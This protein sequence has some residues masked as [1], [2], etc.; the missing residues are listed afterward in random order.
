ML[1]IVN[2]FLAVERER[3]KLILPKGGVKEL[4]QQLTQQQQQV[5]LAKPAFIGRAQVN[6]TNLYVRKFAVKAGS[7][8]ISIET[9]ESLDSTRNYNLFTQRLAGKREITFQISG[10]Y[11]YNNTP[12][13][14][15]LVD[16][17]TITNVKLFVDQLNNKF[18]NLPLATVDSVSV[19]NDM[20]GPNYTGFSMECHSQLGFDYPV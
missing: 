3:R 17:A 5:G 4:Y 6:S 13:S 7:E 9:F 2:K 14:L 20:T 1:T 12:S 19:D 16:G 18:W 10:Y 8:W 15:G 11:D